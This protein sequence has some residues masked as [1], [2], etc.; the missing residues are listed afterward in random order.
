MLRHGDFE[1]PDYELE[2]LG[3]AKNNLVKKFITVGSS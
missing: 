3:K 1:Q 2:S